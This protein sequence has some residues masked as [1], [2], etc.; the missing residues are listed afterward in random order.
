MQKKL[1]MPLIIASTA[2]LTGASA[3]AQSAYYKAI[4]NLN[5][6]VY[7]PLQETV[8]PPINDVET[9]YGTLGPV[10][11]A[12]YSSTWA[13]KGASG[14]IASE[15]DTAVNFVSTQ[16]GG[17]LEV[18]TWDPRNTITSSSFSVEAWVN[19]A[20]YSGDIVIVS[21]AGANPGS[22]NNGGGPIG[23]GGAGQTGWCLG[24]N[25]DGLTDQA[26]RGFGFHVYNGLTPAGAVG[27]H[28]GADITIGTNAVLN[29]WYHLVGVFDGTNAILYINGVNFNTGSSEFI[30][31]KVPMP[32]GTSYVP[33]SWEPICIGGGRGQNA[34]RFGGMIDEVAIYTNALSGAQVLNHFNTALNLSPATPYEQVITNDKAYMYWRMDSTGYNAPAQSSYPTAAYWASNGFSMNVA[35][36][37]GTNSLYGTATMPGVLGPQFSGMFDPNNGNAS[38]G[39]AINGIGGNNGAVANVNI[40]NSVSVAQSIPVDAGY[41]TLVDPKAP[42]FSVTVWFK[43][44]P[45]DGNRF[46]NIIGHSDNGWRYAID[47][48]GKVH[49]KPGNNGTEITSA[50][51]CNDGNWHQAVA[52]V[53]TSA[54]VL[55]LDGVLDTSTTSATTFT[56]CPNDVILGGDP[57]YLNSGNGTYPSIPANGSA[58]AQR[59][60]GGSI[61][62]VAFFN[63]ALSTAN[64]TSLFGAAGV[65][66]Y[67]TGQPFGPRTNGW[68]Y[69]GT[70]TYFFVGVTAKGSP[71]L[72]Y[73]WYFT[74][75]ATA[76]G[77]VLTDGA[78]YSNS[79]TLQVTIS[80]L[81]DSDSGTYYVVVTNSYGAVTSSIGTLAG[82]IQIYNEPQIL[83]QSPAGGSM[84]V[85]SGQNIPFSVTVA[86]ATNSLGYQWYTNGVPYPGATNS[87]FTAPTSTNVS[88]ESVKVIVSNAFG[89]A[90]NAAVTINVIPAPTPPT[91]AY[92]QAI[93]ALNPA[94]YWPMH[95][96]EPPLAN[97]D[98]ETNYGS[99]GALANAYYGDWQILDAGEP[100]VISHNQPGPLA[101][102][103]HTA[104]L[105]ESVSG[106][107]SGASYA[108][109]PRT[110]PLTTI[111]A[112]FTLEAWVQPLQ[113]SYGIILSV[114]NIT[115]NK[116]LNGGANQAGFDWNWAGTA[117]TFSLT[118]RNG[119]GTGST[120]PKTTASYNPGQWYHLVS[121][122]DGTNVA[123]YVNGVQDGLQNSSAAV[124]APN[125]WDPITI[126][127]GR[128]TGGINNTFYG[129]IANVAVYSNVLTV[130]DIQKHYND[131]ATGANGTYKA[132]VL[133]DKPL[134]FYRMDS[135]AYVPQPSNAW[136]VLTNYGSSGVQGVYKPNSTPGGGVGPNVA[137][138]PPTALAC[139][140]NSI[141]ADAGYDPTFNTTGNTAS[142][143]AL[144]FKLNPCDAAER[145][146]QTFM[147]HTDQNWRCAVNGGTGK[148]GFDCGNGLDQATANQ[149]NDGNWHF[150]VGTYDGNITTSIYLDG[151]LS[152]SGTKSGTVGGQTA[153]DVY[154]GS[155]PN[156]QSNAS[157]GRTL[158]GSMC[159]AAFFY[160]TNLSAAQ[161]SNLYSSAEI[162]PSITTQPVSTNAD[163][164]NAFTNTVVAVSPTPLFY[165]WYKNN[166]A[167]SGA[168]NSALVI[169]PVLPA[170]ASTNYV[171]VVSNNFGAVT[172]ASWSLVV[173]SNPII[174]R[175]VLFTSLVLLP[176]DMAP[177]SIQAVGATPLIYQWYSN[178]V[179]I[180]NGTNSTFILAGTNVPAN[181]TNQYVCIVTNSFG[182]ATSSV[183]SV[184]VIGPPPPPPSPD[185]ADTVTADNPMAFWRLD[186]CPDN[187]SGNNG[188][189]AYDY[190]NGNDGFY[191]NA[192]I[193]QSP[194]YNT[195][196]PTEG[197]ATFGLLSSANGEVVLPSYLDFATTGNAN[198]SVEAWVNSGGAIEST[199]GPIISKGFGGGGEEFCLDTA[200][201]YTT[202]TIT[203]LHTF[204]FFIRTTIGAAPGIVSSIPS[205]P[206]GWHH[207]VGVCNESSNS[208]RLYVDGALAGTNVLTNGSG[209][210]AST[211]YPVLIGARSGGQ[212]N[213]D[214][215]NSD[216][217]YVGSICQVALY[218][219]ALTGAQALAHYDSAGVVPNIY[220]EPPATVS[221]DENASITITAA[222]D[223]S[224]P[225]AFQW[226]DQNMNPLPGQT[227]AT[228]TLNNVSFATN[229]STFQLAVSN[230]FGVTTSSS[231]SLTVNH[232]PPVIVQD[233]TSLLLSALGATNV[234]T[235]S[236]IGTEPFTYTWYQNG[237]PI[238]GATNS[239]YTN[240]TAYGSNSY[241]VNIANIYAPSTNSQ[242]E[243]IVGSVGTPPITFPSTGSVG[244]TLDNQ[245]NFLPTLVNG[246]LTITSNAGSESAQAWYNTRVNMNRF[247]VEF[248]YQDVTGGTAGADGITFCIQTTGT[249]AEGGG[250]GALG[251]SGIAPSLDFA[252]NIYH[253][254]GGP[255]AGWNINGGNAGTATAPVVLDAGSD[256]INVYIYYDGKTARAWMIDN[257]ASTTS[258]VFSSASVLTTPLSTFFGAT[259]AFVGFTGATGGSMA[260]QEVY[261]FSYVDLTTFPTLTA[262]L[263]NSPP[264]STVVSWPNTTSSLFVLQSAP[265]VLG[266]WTSITSGITSAPGQNVYTTSNAGSAQFYRLLLAVP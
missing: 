82:L 201:T 67:I 253:G 193:C 48:N 182:M 101:N 111:K 46:Q 89:S 129:L 99:L 130:T 260:Q 257:V 230:S 120:E 147:G 93:L 38:Y 70:N 214:I 132:D 232:G 24:Y 55:Y 110:S 256:P 148:V 186:E 45:A 3:F 112:P 234:L 167:I 47:N 94:G 76:T 258:P 218:N 231:V 240:I 30:V 248:T 226:F 222:A 32:A 10:A 139:D 91:N 115:A 11:N 117:N 16:N 181:S 149:Y 176:G 83:A 28:G 79:Q 189:P 211:P 233:L 227:N 57:M 106:L 85:I 243:V 140:G 242:T 81:V 195:N 224:L 86:A 125:T 146:W 36:G 126:G 33:N 151:V 7:W 213:A 265:S 27:A 154:L 59:V 184:V 64:V 202:S 40:G 80:N 136:P 43:G 143:V 138:F 206:V 165:Q 157:G 171:V 44:N 39:V 194:G 37:L 97:R 199:G 5:P 60:F 2:L 235:V 135:P 244:W 216:I 124:L 137:G 131:G 90:T 172:S 41:N 262:K 166:G 34:N 50:R 109:I 169:N 108:V 185:Y 26:V 210:V 14:V 78:K 205:S 212:V 53:T 251:V 92:A 174:V 104:V 221:V 61:A 102:D 19:P 21:Q 173:N 42:P 22:L 87:T 62:H 71:P 118:V 116:G 84:T 63:Y 88:G 95:E 77:F 168:T 229:G 58:Y 263:T 66:P 51:V 65:A 219:Y 192:Y 225:L 175:D 15:A 74:N 29:T 254:S 158:A 96:V 145:N 249:G 153:Y 56:G 196:D 170:N 8:Q 128:W 180:G 207:L 187:G 223:G 188:T 264:N 68:A 107:P 69:N 236:A 245:A 9:N 152:S 164:N 178:S 35:S 23:A 49:F 197:T 1:V 119:S 220:V 237:S 100:P 142:S 190:W 160:G 255:A 198:F 203:N 228:L 261:N 6:V 183:V 161:V 241:Y 54:E 162:L 252:M 215:G 134:L 123:F 72:A 122:Y 217:Q 141:F 13:T 98:M 156:G 25:Y 114:G 246:I 105:F 113:N 52:T 4:T 31:Q 163:E 238:S 12:V 20:N 144:W 239:S 266:P 121:T 259:T 177:L 103:P 208:L 209:I 150:L 204:R 73:Q 155:S 17:F 75:S 133:A 191:T 127:G 250:G 159:E 200:G 18:P 179:P 247:L